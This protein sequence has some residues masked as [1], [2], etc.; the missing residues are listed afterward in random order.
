MEVGCSFRRV[1]AVRFCIFFLRRPRTMGSRIRPCPPPGLTPGLLL[2]FPDSLPRHP[3][4]FTAVGVPAWRTAKSRPRHELNAVQRREAQKSQ[5]A[6][7][8]THDGVLPMCNSGV[9]SVLMLCG[10]HSGGPPRTGGATARGRRGARAS[11]RVEDRSGFAPPVLGPH[12]TRTNYRCAP[13]LGLRSL[14]FECELA[15]R[16]CAHWAA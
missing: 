3:R 11:D 10:Q 15:I 1:A 2:N 4:P 5:P 12:R 14:I 9:V 6:R 16:Q 8:L 13:R 7:G